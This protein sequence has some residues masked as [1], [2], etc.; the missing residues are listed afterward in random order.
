MLLSNIHLDTSLSSDESGSSY[1]KCKRERKKKNE[2]EKM[3]SKL[4]PVDGKPF[5]RKTM[6][7]KSLEKLISS[8]FNHIT[9]PP[10][11]PP[12]HSEHTNGLLTIITT[13]ADEYNA[14]AMAI[15]C[16][17]PP[18]RLMPPAPISVRSPM[19]IRSISGFNAHA[20]NTRS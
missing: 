12:E 18:D 16:L 5:K 19:G 9:S 3:L 2:R 20:D 1:L 11:L 8:D 7:L 4:N 10:S 15:R 14:R 6:R 17:C 13:L